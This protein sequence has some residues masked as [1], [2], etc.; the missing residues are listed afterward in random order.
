MEKNLN[1]NNALEPIEGGREMANWNMAAP[2][3]DKRI[4]GHSW[5]RLAKKC[6]VVVPVAVFA[7]G[8]DPELQAEEQLSSAC[9]EWALVGCEKNQECVGLQ[10]SLETCIVAAEQECI[11]EA[12][13]FDLSCVETMASELE[14]CA[15]ELRDMT[16]EEYCSTDET[17]FTFCLKPCFFLCVE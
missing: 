5:L 8:G 1:I 12:R 4:L 11:A 15:P 9:A 7:C 16:C 6:L 14:Q 3:P 2:K 17:G 10:E 13:D